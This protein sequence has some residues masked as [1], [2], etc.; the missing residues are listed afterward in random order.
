MSLY[1]GPMSTYRWQ[2]RL[3]LVALWIIPSFYAI[4]LLTQGSFNLFR[5]SPPFGLVFNSMLSHLL[6]GRFDVDA[7]AIGAESFVHDG[8][9]ITYFGIFGALLRL[10]LLLTGNLGQKDV[11]TLSMSIA[12][13][14]NW[15]FR[16]ATLLT[17]VRSVP[18]QFRSIS[19]IVPVI[20]GMAFDGESI[21]FLRESIYQEVI[22]WATTLSSGFVFFLI[23]VL[24]K[25]HHSQEW[26]LYGM[27]VFAGLTLICRPSTAIGLYAALGLV[28][29]VKFARA[30]NGW[31][32]LVRSAIS[33]AIAR[34]VAI[35]AVFALVAG[36]VNMGRWGN[37]FV[38]VDM[39]LYAASHT[40]YFDRILR[41]QRDGMF[42]PHRMWFGLQYYLAP[43]WYLRL[44]DGQFVWQRQMLR[45]ADGVELPPG[46]LLLSDP[47]SCVLTGFFLVRVANRAIEVQV[48]RALASLSLLGLAVPIWLI[49]TFIYFAHRYR[50]EFYPFLNAASILGFV[51]L[52]REQEKNQGRWLK[53]ITGAFLLGAVIAH[54]ELLLYRVVPLGPVTDFKMNGGLLGL[55]RLRIEGKN[56]YVDRHLMP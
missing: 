29:L 20:G 5:P 28:L 51:V 12:V 9:F 22:V 16:L 52:L 10:P 3:L 1:C 44:G 6:V 8:Q 55:I 11:T 45:L 21:Q 50:M 53:I 41:L 2:V 40:V 26:N 48:D 47:M 33:S 37:P 15:L 31:R 39:R 43:F 7:E 25:E 17:A 30:F 54:A 14:L 42:N 38:F 46:S 4:E 34:A 32:P 56:V 36:I 27:A 23:R 35:L 49:L 13:S 24:L 18:P 19:L